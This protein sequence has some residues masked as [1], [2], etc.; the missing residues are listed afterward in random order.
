[1]LQG[2]MECVIKMHNVSTHRCVFKKETVQLVADLHV[3]K[4]VGI[5]RH[6]TIDG[7]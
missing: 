7:L 1:M 3:A 6:H 2:V 5:K 4:A